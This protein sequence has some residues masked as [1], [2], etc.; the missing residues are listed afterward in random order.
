MIKALLEHYL[1]RANR[2]E[3]P[4]AIENCHAMGLHSIMLSADP[5]NQ[6]RLFITTMEHEMADKSLNPTIA[7]HPHHCDVTLIPVLGKV[8]NVVALAT[9]HDA[10]REPFHVCLWQSGVVGK[11]KLKNTG[12]VQH[13]DTQALAL[14]KPVFMPARQLHTVI[15][16]PLSVAAWLVQEGAEDT[17]YVPFCLSRSPDTF[18]P[19]CLYKK[20][21]S[22]F[23]SE[24][25]RVVLGRLP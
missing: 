14:E 25:L 19:D 6:L 10:D 12:L 2:G 11:A 1:R 21:D 8:Q 20:R 22:A 5:G 3:L 23:A 18:M 9:R 7:Y 16:P 15:V 13:I 24:M 4:N 17:D